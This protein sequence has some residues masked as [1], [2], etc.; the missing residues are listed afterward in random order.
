MQVGERLVQLV[1]LDAVDVEVQVLEKRT[2]E[3]S[4]NIVGVGWIQLAW[5]CQ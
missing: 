3:L 1:G 2:V 5:I 4:P